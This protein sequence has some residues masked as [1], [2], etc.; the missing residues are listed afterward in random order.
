MGNVGLNEIFLNSIVKP[1]FEHFAALSGV[2]LKKTLPSVDLKNFI[3][4]YFDY[5][6]DP[7]S[8]A[9]WFQLISPV[10]SQGYLNTA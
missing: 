2:D 1:Y 8:Y 4:S 9:Q 5:R 6:T 7:N 10:Y 3:Q